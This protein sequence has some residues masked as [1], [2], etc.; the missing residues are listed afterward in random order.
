MHLDD[1]LGD[2]EA[3]ART[4]LGLGIGAVDLMELREN[5]ILLIKWYTG[6]GV[7][8]RDGEVAIL[9]TR[10]D[11]H[12]AGISELDGVPYEVEQHLREALFVP[13]ANRERLV[14]GRRECEL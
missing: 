8:H 2:G 10:G 11:A 12:L 1:L 4:A 7:C 5:P 9:S 13:E 3:Q 14:H 6:A